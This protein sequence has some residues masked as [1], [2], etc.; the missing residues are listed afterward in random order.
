M[1][2]GADVARVEMDTMW[3]VHPLFWMFVATARDVSASAWDV[4]VCV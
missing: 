2:N 4:A 1:H 3:N